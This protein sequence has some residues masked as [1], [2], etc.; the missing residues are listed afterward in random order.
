MLA[1]LLFTRWL[2]SYSSPFFFYKF[3][4]AQ[5]DVAFLVGYGF[6]CGFALEALLSKERWLRISGVTY[7]TVFLAFLPFILVYLHRVREDWYR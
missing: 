3:Y 1:A 2:G 7:S 6:G 5:L 4:H